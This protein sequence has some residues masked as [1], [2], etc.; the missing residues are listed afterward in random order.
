MPFNI[1][2]E[3][4]EFCYVKKKKAAG[5]TFR[6]TT[7]VVR[8]TLEEGCVWT[9]PPRIALQSQNREPVDSQCMSKRDTLRGSDNW[10]LLLEISCLDNGTD[11][12]HFKGSWHF[13][14][15]MFWIKRTLLFTEVKYSK[16]MKRIQCFC[17]V[18]SRKLSLKNSL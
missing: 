10:T 2:V 11:N 16:L 5:S 12:I 4:C 18:G 1:Y 17:L 7:L 15:K 8:I 6:T 3:S 13:S 9:L 14:R